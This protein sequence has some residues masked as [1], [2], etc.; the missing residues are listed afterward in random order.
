MILLVNFR[1]TQIHLSLNLI[2]L[3][4][5]NEYCSTNKIWGSFPIKNKV[6]KLNHS[7]RSLSPKKEKHLRYG[8]T[9]TAK[10]DLW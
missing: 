2:H 7:K 6:Q 4:S 10:G 3:S 1:F 5:H 8:Y 9:N